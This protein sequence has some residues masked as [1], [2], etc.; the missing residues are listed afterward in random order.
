MTGRAERA[1]NRAVPIPVPLTGSSFARKNGD[2]D[3]FRGRLILHGSIQV[4]LRSMGRRL[5]V[6]VLR[7]VS[8]PFV[9]LRGSP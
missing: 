3:G 6:Y 8:W 4:A 7:V 1:E 9:G 5:G 2:D